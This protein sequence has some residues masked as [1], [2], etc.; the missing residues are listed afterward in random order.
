LGQG[1]PPGSR[2]HPSGCPFLSSLR[3]CLPL[4]SL[5]SRSPS[6]NQLMSLETRGGDRAATSRRVGRAKSTSYPTHRHSQKDH[7]AHFD[8]PATVIAKKSVRK[9]KE[10]WLRNRDMWYNARV[11]KLM[12]T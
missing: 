5:A 1:P 8:L 9:W 11:T 7:L 2:S 3:P 12:D 4:P 10:N 6:S